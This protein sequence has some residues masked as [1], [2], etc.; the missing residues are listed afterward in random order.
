MPPSADVP[1]I[2]AR[3]RTAWHRPPPLPATRKTTSPSLPTVLPSSPLPSRSTMR[4]PLARS[5]TL[6]PSWD[7]PTKANRPKTIIPSVLPTTPS[8]TSSSAVSPAT[9]FLTAAAPP[10]GPCTLPSA[11]S[12]IIMMRSTWQN[13][14]SVT[15]TP[16]TLPKATVRA[17]SRPC[18]LAGAFPKNPGGRTSAR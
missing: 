5:T 15:T 7:M 16:P 14:I 9:R 17:C 6:P 4:R 2:T 13:S 10:T 1:S 11:A 8:T 3:T 18:P 12:P